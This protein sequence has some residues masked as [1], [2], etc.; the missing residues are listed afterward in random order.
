MVGSNPEPNIDRGLSHFQA[1]TLSANEGAATAALAKVNELAS[2]TTTT[3][4]N[5][6]IRR[7]VAASC[8]EVVTKSASCKSLHFG[9]NYNNT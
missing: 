5:R 7:A 2:G 1:Q 3:A 9:E 6:R 8:S 4:G